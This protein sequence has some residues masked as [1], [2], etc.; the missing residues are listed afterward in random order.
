MFFQALGDDAQA[1]DRGEKMPN[2][3]RH[4]VFI[5][6]EKAELV[7]Q[8]ESLIQRIEKEERELEALEQAMSM[9]KCSNDQYRETNLRQTSKLETDEISD[10]KSQV[11]SRERQIK[12]VLVTWI[13][14]RR[15]DRSR[16]KFHFIL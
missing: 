15:S 1:D 2:H 16:A 6:Q 13:K 5:A 14:L 7:D 11:Y 12:Q 9:L 3:A 8:S 10:L 4:L